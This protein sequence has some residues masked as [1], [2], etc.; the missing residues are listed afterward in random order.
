MPESLNKTRPQMPQWFKDSKLWALVGDRDPRCEIRKGDTLVVI[1]ERAFR[2]NVD[3]AL[4]N[5]EQHLRLDPLF[6]DVVAVKSGI[7][8]KLKN[9]NGKISKI[10]IYVHKDM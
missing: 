5:I 4:A 3:T 8:A 6:E 9:A 10:E 1:A 2:R 7:T